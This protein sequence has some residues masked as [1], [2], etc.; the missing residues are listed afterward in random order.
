MGQKDQL[1]RALTPMD[2]FLLFKECS[3]VSDEDFET[4]IAELIDLLG[5]REFLHVQVKKLSLGQ[6]MKCELIAAL[7]HNPKVLF[8]DEPT[9]G[10]D[11]VAQKNVREFI[12][13]YNT[14]KKTTIILTSHYMDDIRELCERVIIIN[15]GKIVYDGSIDSLISEYAKHKI[16][17]ITLDRRVDQS[18]LDTFGPVENYQELVV[19]LRV[20][21]AEVKTVSSRIMNSD[22][23]IADISIHE[24]SIDDVIRTIFEQK[25]ASHD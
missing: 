21:R 18:M 6:K 22:L 25:V 8:L 20:L 12:K 15:H 17:Q 7:L 1:L 24:P 10:L 5:V 4:L 23:P 13:K 3:E 19:S 11:V 16:I 9:I 14:L 2:N